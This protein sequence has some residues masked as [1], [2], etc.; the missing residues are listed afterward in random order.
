MLFG[1]FF[2]KITP[3]LDNWFF[4]SSPQFSRGRA[5]KYSESISAMRFVQ[6]LILKAAPS[7]RL[8]G[9]VGFNSKI[10]AMKLHSFRGFEGFAGS[11]ART[12]AFRNAVSAGIFVLCG[13]GTAVA[14]AGS[15][16]MTKE[17][18]SKEAETGVVLISSH[19]F[20]SSLLVLKGMH[21][22]G[23]QF[24]DMLE[25]AIVPAM[26]PLTMGSVMVLCFGLK[27][28]DRL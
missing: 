22:A 1:H 23:N 15:E 13:S 12:K 27:F 6:S 17:E 2:P 28:Y 7:C 20:Q 26:G 19:Q 8:P 16:Q 3:K 14:C 24:I 21:Y 4:Y 9:I 11:S 25:A 5:G 18:V 10:H